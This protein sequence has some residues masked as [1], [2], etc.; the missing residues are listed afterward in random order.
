MN[1]ADRWLFALSLAT[2]AGVLVSIAAAQILMGLALV[3]WLILRPSGPH[4]P[5]WT[6]P[7]IAF[8]TATLVSLAMSPQPE[9]GFGPVRKFVLFAMGILAATFVRSESRLRLT[10]FVLLAVAAIGS[11][12]AIVQFIAQY[13]EFRV[14]GALS[15]DPTILARVTGFMGH[16]MTYSGEQMLVW[17]SAV[18]LAGVFRSRLYWAMLSVVG[19]GILL[20]F[21]RSVWLGAAAGMVLMA[22]YLPYQRLLRLLIPVSIVAVVASGLIFNRIAVSFMEEDFAPDSSRLAMLDVGIRMVE[23]HPLFGVGPE[24]ISLLFPDYYRGDSL[25][26]FFYGHLHNNLLQI[27]AERGL[28]A[29]GVL[30]WLLARIGLD[31]FRFS[32]SA[33]PYVKWTAVAGLAVWLAFLVEGLFEY[34]FGD[35]EVLMLFMFLVSVPYGMASG[36]E[37]PEDR[38]GA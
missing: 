38:S 11:S 13:L 5:G 30:L 23:D 27:A 20:S 10:A 25:D 16:W 7:V 15:D 28:P 34:S 32:R 17:C 31:L 21:T 29:L 35:S 12:V 14:T 9:L 4:W 36:T 22:F 3:S 18:P 1:S 8:I 19:I 26:R 33:Q 2:A 24:R 37:L 6:L